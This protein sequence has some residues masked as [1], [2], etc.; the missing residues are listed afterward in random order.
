MKSPTAPP[1]AAKNDRIDLSDIGFGTKLAGQTG[2]RLLNR[3][4]SLN[5]KREGLSI[6]RSSS[7]Y[8]SAL[9][10]SWTRFNLIVACTALLFN[11]LFAFAYLLCGQGALTGA[12]GVTFADRFLDAFFFSVQ[13]PQQSAT[14]ISRRPGFCLML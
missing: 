7:L 12:A 2:Q 4:G 10:I 6:R 13:I 3:D 9:S 1:H 11:T 8:H 5:V 14:A